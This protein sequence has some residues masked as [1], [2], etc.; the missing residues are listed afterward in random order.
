MRTLDKTTHGLVVRHRI[1]NPF[2]NEFAQFSNLTYLLILPTW[3]TLEINI[4]GYL[5]SFIDGFTSI[6]IF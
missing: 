6:L 2:K 1:K 5:E 3:M 4:I